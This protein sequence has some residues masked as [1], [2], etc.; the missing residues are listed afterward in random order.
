[1]KKSKTLALIVVILQAALSYGQTTV[2][3]SFFDSRTGIRVIPDEV[4]FT[5]DNG[6]QVQFSV[7]FSIKL[8]L[9]K[10]GIISVSKAG[11]SE[12][13]KRQTIDA[14]NK[15][16][17]VLEFYLDPQFNDGRYDNAV[18]VSKRMAGRMLLMGTVVDVHGKPILEAKLVVNN[19]ILTKT[20]SDGFF[21]FYIDC[22]SEQKN[23]DLSIVKD[24]YVTERNVGIICWPNGDLLLK[25]R[26]LEGSGTTEKEEFNY[27]KNH[28]DE[29][30][31]EQKKSVS[32]S[33]SGGNPNVCNLNS[34]TVGLTSSFGQCCDGSCSIG[35]VYSI[36]QYTKQVL[37]SEW[38]LGNWL[39]LSGISEAYRAGSVAI[40]TYGLFFVLNPLSGTYDICSNAC[41]QVFGSSTNSTTSAAVD[42]TENWVLWDW[43]EEAYSQYSSENNNLSGNHCVEGWVSANG[44]GDGSF[45][46]SYTGSPCYLDPPGTGYIQYG[47]GKGMSQVGSARWATGLDLGSWC[48][49]SIYGSGSGSHGYGTKSWTQILDHYYSYYELVNCNGSGS[50]GEDI[51]VINTSVS[52]TS[53]SAGSTIDVEAYHVYSGSVPDASLP[54]FDLDYY[55]STDCN[56]SG[57]D[58]FLDGDASSL[59]SDDPFN[60]ETETLTIPGGTSP[61]TYYVLFVADADNELAESDEGNNVACVQITVTGGGSEDITV[62][63]ASVSPSSVTA[64]GTFDVE[65]DHNYSG[66]QLDAD[67]PSFDLDYY[68]SLDCNFTSADVLLGGDVSGLGSDDPTN[69]ETATLTMPAGTPSGNYYILFVADADDELSE[70]NENNNV[71]CVS[72][73]VAGGGSEDITVTNASVSPSSVAAGGTFDVEADHNYSGNQ[74]DANLPSFDLDYYF[75]LDCNFTSADVL[76][77]GDLSGLGSDDPTNTETATLTMPAG[78]PAGNYYIL[79]VADADD[80]LAESNENNNVACVPIT[81][82][83]GGAN[84]VASNTTFAVSGSGNNILDLTIDVVNTGDIE[85]PVCNMHYY[86]SLDNN[87]TTSDFEIESDGIS[88]LDPNATE[89]SYESELNLDLCA[90]SAGLSGAGMPEGTYYIG[91]ILDVDNAVNEPGGGESDNSGLFSPNPVTF[92]CCSAP[93]TPTINNSTNYSIDVCQGQTTT[94]VASDICSGCSLEWSTGSTSSVITVGQ[95]TY[96]VSAINNCGNAQSNNATVGVINDPVP[97]NISV[98]ANP[99]CQGG[100]TVL[101][102]TNTA[103]CDGCVYNWSPPATL[104]P[105]SGPQVTATPSLT[106]AYTATALNGCGQPSNTVTIIVNQVPIPVISQN[107]GVLECNPSNGFDYQ[108]YDDN[109]LIIG[110]QYSTY[111]PVTNGNYYVVI[112][113]GNNCSNTSAAFQML[114]VGL[115][116]LDFKFQLYPNPNQGLFE[117]ILP[118]MMENAGYQIFDNLGQLVLEG[119]IVSDRTQ[120]DMEKHADG[121][122]VLRLLNGEKLLGTERLVLFRN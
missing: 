78:T 36:Q 45:G 88:S 105:I 108:W 58:V 6:H 77:G 117:L 59:G 29:G 70:S 75:S 63:N 13:S 95:G 112:T 47:H 68:F 97:P 80:E 93:T 51:T 96:Y 43:T 49:G 107:G 62:T 65:A 46:R 103:L 32:I 28:A 71:A 16:S 116:E 10:T 66:N 22:E 74:L 106:T 18:I 110:A 60:I 25:S 34:I 37:P 122:Y 2:N 92:S 84:V 48:Q 82:T 76:L 15:G 113:D 81:V 86:A 109:G 69:T 40:R 89:T 11:Y 4:T 21:Q 100:S 53:V 99:I 14:D 20:D 91:Y 5:D 104:S 12:L 67:L 90:I 41:C 7:D 83:G 27:Q 73:T 30:Y 52:P 115:E 94:L 31:T 121:V 9:D 57:N 19:E 72:I 79:F 55:L 98:S 102:V 26:L 114:T 1:M 85:S 61:G 119:S 120:I 17:I 50:G 64:G 54:S 111:A 35:Q 24:G 39:S 38:L 101:T 44:C 3:L 33:A 118:E 8:E 87:I 42:Y 23:V 56:F